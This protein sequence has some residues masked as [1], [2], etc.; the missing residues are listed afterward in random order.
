M[1]TGL[2]PKKNLRSKQRFYV[3]RVII[4][5]GGNEQ[6]VQRQGAARMEHQEVIKKN[7]AR[8]PGGSVG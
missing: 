3:L 2:G 8:V 5:K 7:V 1:T 6:N 4:R